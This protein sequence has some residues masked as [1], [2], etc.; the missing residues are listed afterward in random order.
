LEARFAVYLVGKIRWT[1][2]VSWI[3]L[4]LQHI[5]ADNAGWAEFPLENRKD[6]LGIGF[7]TGDFLARCSTI[8]EPDPVISVQYTMSERKLGGNSALFRAL[9]PV[10]PAT[11]Q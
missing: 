11:V 10:E 2:W 8:G 5:A 3:A 7:E 9:K 6:L 4:S 1:D